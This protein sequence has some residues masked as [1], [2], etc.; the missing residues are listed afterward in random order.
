MFNSIS[1][2]L[3]VAGAQI[4]ICRSQIRFWV[5]SVLL[6]LVVL[7]G[8]LQSCVWQTLNASYSPSFSLAEPKYLLS[9]VDALVF[10][11][12]QF[13]AV[14][15]TFDIRQ[16]HDRN[17]IQ[18]VLES[19]QLTNI[20]Y[21]LGSVLGVTSLLYVVVLCNIALIEGLGAL[22]HFLGSAWGDF[23]EPV[24]VL[25]LLVFDTFPSLFLW[26][27]VALTLTCILR[28][29]FVAVAIASSLLIVFY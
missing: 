8:Y 19:R 16:Y 18:T 15:L 22:S 13:A 20:E 11:A 5:T 23:L 25:N 2:T 3:A 4:R 10:L 12:F 17:R 28:S 24:S 6:T 29:G 9:N 26:S 27:S 7:I 21:L 14:L 1:R